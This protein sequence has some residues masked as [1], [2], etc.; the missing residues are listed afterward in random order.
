MYKTAALLGM[1]V[2]TVVGAVVVNSCRPADRMVTK[3]KDKVKNKIDEL[4]L[5]DDSVPI[6]MI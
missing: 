2:G 6:D 1:A 3:A 4:M 5:R